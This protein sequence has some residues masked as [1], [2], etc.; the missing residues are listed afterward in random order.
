MQKIFVVTRK[1]EVPTWDGFLKQND[2]VA[3][4][5]LESDAVKHKEELETSDVL[6]EC[7]VDFVILDEITSVE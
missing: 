7:Y 3:A 4:F 5:S 1:T 6:C 2:A